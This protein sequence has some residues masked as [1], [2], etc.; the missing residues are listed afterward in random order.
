VSQNLIV[1]F[2]H[3][4]RG[5]LLSKWLYS[6]GIVECCVNPTNLEFKIDTTNHDLVPFYN[7]VLFSWQTPV[8][9][10]MF[11]LLQRELE[12][13]RSPDTTIREILAQSNCKPHTGHSKYNLVL[14]HVSSYIGLKK[15][16]SILD[17]KV[18]RITFKDTAQADETF[19]RIVEKNSPL[20][21]YDYERDNYYRFVANY[22][23]CINV[24]LDRVIDLDLDFLVKELA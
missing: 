22:D 15:L 9:K 5:F 18:I 4:A 14:T 20:E 3:N 2:A 12:I 17:A 1:S 6:K 19:Y 13:V 10:V 11:N 23:F 24:D 7:D 8:E 16:A 21:A